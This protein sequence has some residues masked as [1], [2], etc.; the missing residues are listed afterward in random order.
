MVSATRHQSVSPNKSRL[1]LAVVPMVK[2]AV[3]VVLPAMLLLKSPLPCTQPSGLL[4]GL[5]GH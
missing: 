1:P 4:S 5:D 2:L 3:V